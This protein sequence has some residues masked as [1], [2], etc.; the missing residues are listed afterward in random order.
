MLFVVETAFGN[1]FVKFRL[2]TFKGGMNVPTATRLLALVTTSRRFA[3]ATANT[4]T[5]TAFL[6]EI[7]HEHK[8]HADKPSIHY[9]DSPF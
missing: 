6:K 2:S 3:L 9:V 1:E 5:N 7:V 4:T 8:K